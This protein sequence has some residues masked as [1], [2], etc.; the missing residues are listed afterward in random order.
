[1]KH[2]QTRVFLALGWYE[3]GHM[4]GI[5]RY[6]CEKN[7]TLKRWCLHYISG[8]HP[9][10]TDDLQRFQPHGIISQFVGKWPDLVDAVTA[11]RVPTVELCWA[12]GMRVP[13]VVPDDEAMAALAA[14]HLIERGFTRFVYIGD[15]NFIEPLSAFARAV[16]A[17]GGDLRTIGFNDPE[18][19][20]ESHKIY[21]EFTSVHDQDAAFRRAWACRLF[22]SLE[23]PVGVFV[24]SAALA[25]DIIEGCRKAHILVPEQVAVVS[26]ANMTGEGSGWPVSLTVVVP[27]Y[28]E[29]GYQAALLLD[30]MMKGEKV[31]PDT[32]VRIP[33]KALV[34]RDSTR[35]HATDNLPVAR[36]ASFIMRNLHDTG[37]CAKQ[38]YRAAKASRSILYHDFPRQFKMPVARYI[39][40]LRL[41]E[42]ITLL[43]TTDATAS[44]IAAQCG[45]GDLRRFRSALARTTGKPPSVY[46]L[47]QRESGVA[48]GGALV[49]TFVGHAKRMVNAKVPDPSLPATHP[50]IHPASQPPSFPAPVP[51]LRR[52]SHP[53]SKEAQVE[54]QV[55]LPTWQLDI[56][57]AC[58][59]GERTGRELLHVAGYRNRTGNFKKGVR[60]L[61]EWKLIELTIPAKPNS[62]FQKYRLTAKGQQQV[63]G[64]APPELTAGCQFPPNHQVYHAPRVVA[65]VPLDSGPKACYHTSTM[66]ADHNSI[67]AARHCGS[68]G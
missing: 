1:M 37:L 49:R 36:A 64:C 68:V 46:R 58:A 62:R 54:A 45:F 3:P 20:N 51:L 65:P 9:E 63:S 8:L 32:V 40:H 52:G 39:E 67:R 44:A 48:G 7:W 30:R 21:H 23:K 57:A 26:R 55:E 34:A 14:A 56:L 43:E 13:R 25:D 42:A 11:A 2:A 60:H 19:I 50:L 10:A 17:V 38:V 18:I 22:S 5:R 24:I 28:E 12:S 6:A 53:P 31:P 29:Q 47:R 16:H 4:E 27:D 66:A 61:V 35:C 41:K 59:S 33:P 15:R